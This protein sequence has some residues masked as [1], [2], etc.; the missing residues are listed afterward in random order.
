[1]KM[2]IKEMGLESV[3]WLHLAQDIDKFGGGGGGEDD[4]EA[5]GSI[6]CRKFLNCQKSS[7]LKHCA[8]RIN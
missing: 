7:V 4:S 2:G 1:M 3:D 5:A 8:P 6:K